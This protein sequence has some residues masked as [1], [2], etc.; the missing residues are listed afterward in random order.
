MDTDKD[1]CLAFKDEWSKGTFWCPDVVAATCSDGTKNQ[2]ETGVDCGGVCDPC[3]DCKPDCTGKSCGSDGCSG[4]CAPGCTGDEVCNSSGSCG[5]PSDNPTGVASFTWY[6][7]YAPCCKD[8]PN[9]DPSADTTECDLYSACDYPGMFAAFDQKMSFEWVQTHNVVAFFDADH[10]THEEWLALYANKVIRLTKG[11]V[12]VDA[13]IA[14]TC[15]DE[16]CDGCCTE[17]SQPSGRLVDMEYWTVMSTFGDLSVVE[18]EVSYEIL[19]DCG[20]MPVDDCG[21]CGGDNTTCVP[22]AVACA[23]CV[24]QG[25][26]CYLKGW[27]SPCMEADKDACLSYK[28]E[29]STGTFWCPDVVTGEPD[30]PDEPE[31]GQEWEQCGGKDWTGPA[32]CCEGLKCVYSSDFYSQCMAQ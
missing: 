8:N 21:V 22:I 10:P 32:V 27:T 15:G 13:L 28:D 20:S 5:P 7:S 6:E 29:W 4:T 9:Y 12:I 25:K 30:E 24:K 2:N 11:E 18:G 31:C 14:D 3:P 26:N 23:Q 19:N 1:A 17:N 16:D